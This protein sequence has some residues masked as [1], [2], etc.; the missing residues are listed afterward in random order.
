M[1]DYTL[2]DNPFP[3]GSS[4]PNFSLPAT[5]GGAHTLAS[6]EAAKVLV[7]VFMCNHC[8]YVQAYL[9]RLIDLQERFREQ[10]VRF[11]GIN[12]NDERRYPDDSLGKM[13]VLVEEVGLNFPY[14]RDTEQVVTQAYHAERTPQVFV[15]DESRKLVYTGGIDNHYADPDKVTERP[16]QDALLAL[17]EGRPISKPI[18]HFIGCSVKW[19]E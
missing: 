11:V 17:V 19:V 14:L 9:D 18:A 2:A 6:F 1:A 8:P 13:K 7:V 15:F 10:G 12:P 16:L 4:A 3:L 5:D